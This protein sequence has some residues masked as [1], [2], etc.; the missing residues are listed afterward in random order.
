MHRSWAADQN[1]LT[2]ALTDLGRLAESSDTDSHLGTKQSESTSLI[3]TP[4]SRSPLWLLI[5]PEGTITSDEERVK[6]VAYAE[7]EGITDLKQMLHPRSTGLL[8]CLRTLLDQVPD[9][10][11]LDMTIGYPGV[12]AGR[13]PQDYYGLFS[14]F[15][16]GVPP[17]T[18]HIHLK[19]YSDLLN[20]ECEIPAL[21][22]QAGEEMA[23]K[24]KTREFAMWLR[25]IWRE[26]EERVLGFIDRQRF[27]G[28][29]EEVV[30]IRQL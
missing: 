11:L 10:K 6:S 17:P 18:V 23:S 13:Y 27:D 8:F 3:R 1:H 30:P 19:L 15:L 4:S 2:K 26:K 9:L 5:F 25:G 24:E 20:P 28:E 22:K 16:Y 14:V 21:Q 12:P 7:R 29:T